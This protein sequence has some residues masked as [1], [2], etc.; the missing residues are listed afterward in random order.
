MIEDLSYIFIGVLSGLASGL[1]GLGGGIIIVPALLIAFKMMGLYELQTMHVAVATSL[2]T[3]IVT[4]LVSIVSHHRYR[5]IDWS[6]F[7]KLAPSLVIGGLIA[8]FLSVQLS[9][10]LLQHIFSLYLLFSAIKIWFPN[11]DGGEKYLLNTI[12]LWFAGGTVGLVSALVGVGGGTF[13]VPY[14]MM[15]NR[16]PQQAIGTSAACGFPIALAA[17]MGFIVLDALQDHSFDIASL[18]FVHWPAF[19]GI[20]SSS[21]VFSLL[22]ARIASRLQTSTLKRIFSVLLIVVSLYTSMY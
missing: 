20:I 15:A 22:G 8:T 1:L 11:P 19:I 5:N 7:Q 2:M 3:I 9:S 16:P 13:I 14:L 18:G 21:I 12:V 17:I 6:L 4:S 10:K